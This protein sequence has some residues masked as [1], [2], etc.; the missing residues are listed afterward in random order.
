[1]PSW[2]LTVRLTTMLGHGLRYSLP[3]SLSIVLRP[4]VRVEGVPP[5]EIFATKGASMPRLQVHLHDM[6]IDA[7]LVHDRTTSHPSTLKLGSVATRDSV[8]IP[9]VGREHVPKDWQTT[10]CVTDDPGACVR[11]LRSV[12]N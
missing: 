9:Q 4:D 10:A 1:M 11:L 5:T 12:V 2:G 7:L 3:I 8:V 6:A